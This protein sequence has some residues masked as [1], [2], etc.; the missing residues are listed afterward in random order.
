[1]N[2][3]SASRSEENS[4]LSA[5]TMPV[6]GEVQQSR[7]RPSRA[8][9]RPRWRPSPTQQRATRGTCA[10]TASASA[11]APG[12]PGPA[13]TTTSAPARRPR[14]SAA[15]HS[16]ADGSRSPAG[17]AQD[18]SSDH[19]SDCSLR[20]DDDQRPVPQH[21]APAVG[22]A[23]RRASPPRGRARGRQ[24]P[25]RRR[26][27][28]GRREPAQRERAGGAGS[29]AEPVHR[30]QLVQ[31]GP[32]ADHRHRMQLAV[33]LDELDQR[34]VAEGSRSSTDGVGG[35]GPIRRVPSPEARQR[36]RIRRSSAT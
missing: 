2:G 13:T 1:M 15:C 19:G 22:A 11:T 32:A 21:P 28:A 30:A 7:P 26:P 27:S 9:R 36:S 25:R 24:R 4:G 14:A 8:G 10:A 29:V 3:P 6:G 23:C 31:P 16:A 34:G 18:G 35:A 12:R 33:Q 20:R 17:P 5:R